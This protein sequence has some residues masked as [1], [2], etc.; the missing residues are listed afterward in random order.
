MQG[1]RC[2]RNLPR[3][4]ALPGITELMRPVLE[5]HEDGRSLRLDDIAERLVPVFG[6]SDEERRER[7]PSG[8]FVFIQRIGW[9][10]N[11]LLQM[12]L[13]E[14]VNGSMTRITTRGRELAASGDPVPVPPSDW[15]QK[16]VSKE[17]VLAAMAEF[18][19]NGR[20]ATLRRHGYRRALDYVVIHDGKEY[21][22]KAL[23][24]IAY[25]IEYPDEEPIRNRGL[26]GGQ[27]VTQRLEALEFDVR[28][29]KAASSEA[30][31]VWLIRAGREGRYERLALEESVALI[32]WS[33]LG[34]LSPEL[35]RDELKEMIRAHWNEQREASLGSQAGQIYRFIH[36]VSAGDLVVLPLMSDYGHVAV[37]RV[38]GDYVYRADGPFAETDAQNTREVEWLEERLSYERF[39]PD[40]R[41][42][43]GQQGTLS[44]ISK[45]NAAE[46][47]LEV[48]GGADASAIHLVLKWSAKTRADTIE[49][50]R[51]V[52][53]SHGAVWW[54]RWSKPGTTGLSEEWLQKLR[55]QLRGGSLTYVFLHC[56]SATTW[57][58]R[59]LD[60]TTDEADV[61]KALVPPYY[62]SETHHSLWVK[63][64]DFE[65]V[66]PTTLTENYVLA[67]SGDP[68]TPGGLDNQGPLIIREQSGTLPGRFFIL[69]QGAE[70]HGGYDDEEGVRY[71]WTDRSSGAWKQLA[72]SPGAE[73]I[74]YRTGSASD[75]QSYFGTGRIASVTERSSDDDLRHFIADISDY[76]AFDTPVAAT[77]G[78]VR[79]AQTS[80][81]PI[82]RAQFEKLIALATGD[83]GRREFTAAAVRS[84]AEERGLILATEIYEQVVAALTSGKHVIL[85]GPPGT[86]KT[87]LAL[88]I[89]D[90]A[91]DAGMCD[92]YLP[93]TATAD[94][95]TFETIGGLKPTAANELQ[96]EPGHFLA[97]IEERRWLVIDE[98]NRSNFDR[99][100]GQL[101]TVL[102][103]Q[104]VVLPYHRPGKGVERP[105]ALIP[106]GAHPPSQAVDAVEIPLSWRIVATMNVFDKTLLF[107]MSFALMRRFAF[108]EV[109][110]PS[111]AVFEAL[112]GQAAGGEGRAADLSKRLLF[113]RRPPF[114]DLGP[115]VY[116]DLS[117]Y[118][119]ARLAAD[120]DVE[121]GQ[122]LFEAF[123]A[124]LL[125]QFEGIDSA[126]GDQ[127]FTKVTQAVGAARKERLRQTLNA[128]L[129]L[130]LAPATQPQDPSEEPVDVT[131]EA[132][133]DPTP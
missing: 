57:R 116:L 52:A 89:A 2:S 29:K 95:T 108:I 26:Q 9:A 88:A 53:E 91:R 10:R 76:R 24:G 32:G 128:V 94:W 97:A 34:A 123:Y 56:P 130:E 113:L 82:T 85:T 81:Q 8:D 3:G 87:T 79:N 61:D 74:Y 22:S 47:I 62:D 77:L 122:V 15:G 23:Y 36:E 102:S 107:E 131:P 104:S 63:L 115:A 105:I 28:S 109:A 103:G 65:Q 17:S 101:F 80:I 67:R 38:L 98:L 16:P 117:R 121:D 92:G 51:E 55:E 35:S 106:E 14:R 110:S 13:L 58:T 100:F 20:D 37:G 30:P 86:A 126:V 78:P 83:N 59:L 19:R 75:G 31:R 114:K 42:A 40:L 45:P 112:I 132:E 118:I 70:S 18:D 21:D 43:F 84:S 120:A 133:P 41:E 64:V 71:H 7:Q 1:S 27:G 48:L 90:V 44:E 49:R 5:V 73:F 96:F 50:H 124:Y 125:P 12:A 33:E 11:N 127:L 25:G 93:T 66:D 46:R 72:N 69:N 39:D 111:E 54:A 4:M 119:A 129:G 60:I 6:V 68:I 99:A